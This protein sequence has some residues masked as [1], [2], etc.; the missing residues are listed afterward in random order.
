MTTEEYAALVKQGVMDA[1]KARGIY[2]E[3]HA[4]ANAYISLGEGSAKRCLGVGKMLYEINPNV[5]MFEERDAA[6]A[7]I[8]CRQEALDIPA[9]LAQVAWHL[10]VEADPDIREGIDHAAKLLVILDRL[11]ARVG[12]GE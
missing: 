8:E 1:M 5:Q 4:L 9:Y 7:V 6:Q 12:G 3:E 10:D 11:A 2:E